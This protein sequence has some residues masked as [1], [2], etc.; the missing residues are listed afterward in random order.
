MVKED[1][2]P[3]INSAAIA[4]RRA[5]INRAAAAK[6]IFAIVSPLGSLMPSLSLLCLIIKTKKK[7]LIFQRY[8]MTVEPLYVIDF[9][10]V[11]STET[12]L[13]GRAAY[14]KPVP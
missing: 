7:R 2:D 3:I 13:L 4:T 1:L 5:I 8:C 14:P 12:M 9:S 11:L 6:A 10:V